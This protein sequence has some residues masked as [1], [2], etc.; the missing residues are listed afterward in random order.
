MANPLSVEDSLKGRFPRDGHNLSVRQRVVGGFRV[1]LLRESA[2]KDP[3]ILGVKF[4]VLGFSDIT[5]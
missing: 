5:P 2:S 4:P 1:E 3:K